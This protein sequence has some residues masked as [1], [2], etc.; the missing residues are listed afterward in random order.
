MEITYDYDG[1]K[2]SP[3]PPHPDLLAALQVAPGLVDPPAISKMSFGRASLS[4]RTGTVRGLNDGTIFPD[5]HF[6]PTVPPK[7]MRRAALTRAPLRGAVRVAIALVDFPDKRISPNAVQRFRDLFF[8]TGKISTGSAT[9]YF[10]EVS[11]NKISLTGEVVG[12]FRM[13]QTLYEYANQQ[14]G[15]SATAPNAR[16]L[17]ADALK[18]ARSSID[19]AP[20][21]NDKNG[22]VDAFIVV[23]AGRGAEVTGSRNDIWSLKW[24]LPNVVSVNGVNV[25]GFLTIPEDAYVGVCAHELGHL[26]FGWPDLYDIDNSSEGIGNWC[27]MAGGSW[28]GSPP[29]VRPCHPSAW[30]KA[31]QG[32]VQV[33]APNRNGSITVDAVSRSFEIYRLWTGG[34]TASKEYFLLENRA[35]IGFDSSLPG[36]GLTIWHIDESKPDNSDET[37]YQIALEQ[38]DGLNQLATSTAGRGDAGDPYPGT[39]NNRSFTNTSTPNSQSYAGR[40]TGVSITNISDVAASMTMDITV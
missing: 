27:L 1:T 3:M 11:A 20:Y 5:A 34:N 26:L 33:H 39:T 37:H 18:A 17:A 6:Q 10:S 23:H 8:S 7:H 36:F 28:G 13:P 9:E 22:Y 2:P 31:S 4:A 40:V 24:V 21:D 14:H 32:W 12:P 15:T 19:F 30:C 16:T 38:A 29:G 35:R 25:Y